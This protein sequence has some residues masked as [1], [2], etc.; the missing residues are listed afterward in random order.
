[1]LEALPAVEAP[2]F[3]P[4]RAP[5]GNFVLTEF[6]VKSGSAGGETPSEVKLTGA[7]AD[8]SQ[9]QYEIAKAIDGKRNDGNNG[10]AVSNQFGKPHYAAFQLEKPL[11]DAEKGARLRIELHHPREGGFAIA[12]FRVWVTTSATPLNVGLPAQ[13]AEA[14][15]KPAAARSDEE[16]AALTTYW[17]EYDPELLKLRLAAGKLELPPPM[18]PGIPERQAA[19]AQAELPIKLDPKLVQLRQDAEHS[20]AQLANRR[21]TGVQDLT[22]ALINNPAFLFNR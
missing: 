2:A 5:D 16:K 15:K 22:W 18:D 21:L 11:D 12:R 17:R 10:W 14:L 8:H 20:K 6:S 9:E 19:I 3:G 1:L 7:V 4:G 13:V